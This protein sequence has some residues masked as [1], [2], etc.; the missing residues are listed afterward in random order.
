MRVGLFGG[1]FDP[2]H[3]GH[4]AP[5]KEAMQTLHLDR[6]VYLPTAE[7]PHKPGRQ[8]A[9]AYCR[10]AMVEL[11]LLEEP[12]LEVSPF[13]LTPE[14]PAYTIDSLLYF[15]SLYPDSELFLIIG[16]DSFAELETWR[17]W[18]QIV[19]VARLAVLVRPESTAGDLRRR[20]SRPLATLAESERVHFIDNSPVD[21]SATEL[22]QR[23]AEGEDVPADVVPDLVLKY[24]RKYSLY[25]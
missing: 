8:F 15:R 9:P 17:A 14:R 23:L 7:P 25:R 13:E 4:I 21:V 1:S 20:L 24:I 6:V 5:V 16:G 10:Y 12:D 22:R 2:I 18:D 11:A 3:R 19:E